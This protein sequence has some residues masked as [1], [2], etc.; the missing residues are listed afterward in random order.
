MKRH[1]STHQVDF[2]HYCRVEKSLTPHTVRSY[3][4]DIADFLRWRS[5]PLTAKAV[6]ADMIRHYVRHS[7]DE[8]ALK[9]STIRRR[10]ASLRLFFR[11]LEIRGH[12]DSS[13]FRQLELSIRLPQRLP[14]AL[15]SQEARSL[16][17]HAKREQRSENHDA[18]LTYFAVVVLFT[19][20]L[21]ISELTAA[22]LA[23]VAESEAAL[24]VH[25]KGSRERW[26]Y[27]PGLQAA[28]ILRRFLTSRQ[29]TPT[30]SDR[31][32]I[33][34]SGV[35]VTAPWVRTQ[36]RRLAH[37]AQLG[38][39]VTPHMLRHTAATEL[40]EAGVDI[41]FVQRLLGHASISTTQIYAHVSD[42]ALRQRLAEANTLLRVAGGR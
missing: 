12:V 26:V 35:P 25:G 23:D 31:L 34:A 5:T 6:T 33:R 17:H 24:R 28:R 16:L 18:L 27:I 37:G 29:R 13:V 8:R 40:L 30:A 19:T 22:K 2:L 14:R 15:S 1:L 3:R 36:L 21:R 42:S 7:F 41:R 11:W 38:R 39:H 20:G 4:S 32:L 9:A 10:L